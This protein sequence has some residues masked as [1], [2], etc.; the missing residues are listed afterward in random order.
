M[1]RPSFQS[2]FQLGL[3]AATASLL[4]GL[5]AVQAIHQTELRTQGMELADSHARSLLA[6]RLVDV[7][8]ANPATVRA[9]FEGKVKF[10]PP[11]PDLTA[12]GYTLLGGRVDYMAGHAAAALIYQL[13][14]QDISVFL[15][16]QPTAGDPGPQIQPPQLGYN[17]VG[18]QAG[19]LAARA[20][21]ELS[22]PELRDFAAVFASKTAP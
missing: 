13:G 12:A 1:L 14:K 3:G 20:V 6:G 19:S 4:I 9:W 10:M 16:P 7:A 18:W 15:W 8:S 17:I 21:S 5:V 2:L 11:V 22:G